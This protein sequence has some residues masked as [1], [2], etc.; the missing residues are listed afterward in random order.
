MLSLASKVRFASKRY[1]Q[2]SPHFLHIR[3]KKKSRLWARLESPAAQ[4]DV[5]EKGGLQKKK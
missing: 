1:S 2:A 4:G 3:E 5:K